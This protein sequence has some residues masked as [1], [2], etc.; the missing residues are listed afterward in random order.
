MDIS[1]P[2]NSQASSHQAACKKAVT[3]AVTWQLGRSLRDQI[4]ELFR[5]LTGCCT[6]Q[7]TDGIYRSGSQALQLALPAALPAIMRLLQIG[8]DSWPDVKILVVEDARVARGSTT[9]AVVLSL[10]ILRHLI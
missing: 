4:K 6:K 7:S 10:S 2:P 5:L 3:A 9:F 8:L 1:K